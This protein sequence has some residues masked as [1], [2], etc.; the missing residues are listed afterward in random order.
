PPGVDPNS[1][2]ASDKLSMPCGHKL[3]ARNLTV[4]I[5]GSLSRFGDKN[6][7][8]IELYNLILKNVGDNQRTWCNSGIDTDT[9]PSLYH[10]IDLAIGCEQFWMCIAGCRIIMSKTIVY[11]YSGSLV[12]HFKFKC[13]Q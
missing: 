11:F 13:S 2:M 6:T 9:R 12:E 10:R 8:I 5:D 3:D 1:K 7:N 4:C